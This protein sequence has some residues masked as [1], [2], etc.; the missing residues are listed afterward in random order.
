MTRT[1]A[2]LVLAALAGCST[3]ASQCFVVH[4][5]S[6]KVTDSEGRVKF[7][8]A[9]DSIAYCPPTVEAVAKAASA[10]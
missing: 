8:K 5:S 3:T 9:S 1:L 10:P 7:D 4:S 2:I 6:I